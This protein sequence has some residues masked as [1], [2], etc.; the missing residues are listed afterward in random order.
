MKTGTS[1][2]MLEFTQNPF[3]RILLMEAII[4][5]LEKMS[6]D[7]KGYFICSV[8]NYLL[9]DFHIKYYITT[10]GKCTGKILGNPISVIEYRLMDILPELLKHK[11]EHDQIKEK[12]LQEVWFYS[13]SE[14]NERE[15]ITLRINALRECI[16]EI[17]EK[18][19]DQ[20]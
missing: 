3:N 16:K 9:N 7:H 2:T 13:L 18:I 11:H 19:I 12:H 20:L 1:M 6:N 10:C 15:H 5:K 17:N 14:V 4:E 8:I